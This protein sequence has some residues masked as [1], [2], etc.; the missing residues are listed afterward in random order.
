MSKKKN[1][2]KNPNDINPEVPLS[3]SID[4]LKDPHPLP[5]GIKR[6][7]GNKADEQ[8]IT[9]AYQP[10]LEDPYGAPYDDFNC[11][12]VA[13]T[14]KAPMSEAPMELLEI[15][16]K[17]CKVGLSKG[18]G[19]HTWLSEVSIENHLEAL[20]R[21]IR[22]Y[23]KGIDID[24]DGFLNLEAILWRAASACL[25]NHF[26]VQKKDGRWLPSILRAQDKKDPY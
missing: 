10:S 21:H 12:T 23:E 14:I 15:F 17:M 19:A 11:V 24:V 1:P 3:F 9:S 26:K 6:R 16:S 20:K 18:Y 8:I 13:P 5:H 22:D 25:V 4:L 2:I 7:P